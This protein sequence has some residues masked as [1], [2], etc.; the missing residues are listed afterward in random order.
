MSEDS[1]YEEILQQNVRQVKKTVRD[2]DSPDYQK[3]YDLEEDG[4]NRKTVKEFLEPRIEEQEEEEVEQIEEET[5]EGLLGSF[6]RKQIAGGALVLGVLV[7]LAVGYGF[8]GGVSKTSPSALK[9]SVR[10]LFEATGFEGNLSFKVRG[11]N[12]MYYIEVNQ[13]RQTVNGTETGTRAFYAS[14]DGELLFP[15]IRSPLLTNPIN[16]DQTIKQLQQQ[17]SQTGN[18]TQ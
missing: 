6:S 7:G 1:D 17:R 10:D 9:D 14:P 18:S 4:K 2:M 5:E 3:L 8:T 16:I 12:G 13:S 11:T 15:E